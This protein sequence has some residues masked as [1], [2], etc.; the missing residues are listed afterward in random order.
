MLYFNTILVISF[1]GLPTSSSLT[2]LR[3]S[4][5]HIFSVTSVV[6]PNEVALK[7]NSFSFS[8]VSMNVLMRSLTIAIRTQTVLIYL[9]GL[10]VHAR[11]AL[12]AT[13]C[14]VQVLGTS[15]PYGFTKWNRAT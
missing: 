10:P 9:K 12:M 7:H 3:V 13:E 1:K 5:K 15:L 11:M 2:N 8:Q 4:R 14:S 6:T